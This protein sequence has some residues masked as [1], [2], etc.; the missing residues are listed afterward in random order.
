MRTVAALSLAVLILVAALVRKVGYSVLVR[1]RYAL[2][3]V[4]ATLACAAADLVST[5]YAQSIE[6]CV[7]APSSRF[8]S[9]NAQDAPVIVAQDMT[10]S[11]QRRL[12]R[13]G[14]ALPLPPRHLAPIV[15]DAGA[16]GGVFLLRDGSGDE[17]YR[18]FHQPLMPGSAPAQIS[19][20]GARVA[21]PLVLKQSGIAVFSSTPSEDARWG[22]LQH[23]PDGAMR[24]IMQQPGAWQ[25]V[26]ASADGATLLVQEVFGLYDRV[27]YRL[28]R[29]S[30]LKTP[31]FL[32]KRPLAIRGAQ[33]SPNGKL[34]Y[35]ILATAQRSSAIVIAD[36]EAGK[37]SSFKVAQ[38]P[39][40]ALQLSADGSTLTALENRGG[41]SV[42]HIL[43]TTAQNLATTVELEGWAYDLVVDNAGKQ[44]GLT[45]ER[46]GYAA[47]ALTLA[48]ATGYAV[49]PSVKPACADIEVSAVE[50]RRPKSVGGMDVLPAILIEAKA[51]AAALR[52]LIIAF[53]GG[54]EG[55]WRRTSHAELAA[56]ADQL[57]AAIMLPNVAGST[58]YGLRY[59]ATDDGVKRGVVLAEIQLLLDWARAQ[60]RIDAARIAVMGAS[61]GGYLALLAQ[62]Q[63]DQELRGALSHVGISDLGMFL[64]ETPLTRR[65]L[66]R[67][68]YGDERDK[69]LAGQLK[70]YSP[71]THFDAIS[72]PVFLSHGV[73]DARVPLAQSIRLADALRQRGKPVELFTLE[74]EGHVT[75][76]PEARIELTQRQAAFLRQILTN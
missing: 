3:P 33:L 41:T 76:R 34:A 30:G 37:V 23:E 74:N 45:L 25:P 49:P 57:D 36:V 70:T 8:L 7:R 69:S 53:H 15:R 65:A 9:F 40:Y 22:L 39:L 16:R 6:R 50:I 20:A 72:R 68:E 5:G 61:Y 24:I 42:L 51:T 2:A 56:L 19:L 28:D 43:P 14:N 47:Q 66:R 44:V 64:S 48:S 52:P 75:R 27:L 13:A 35:V 55:Q 11:P 26:A 54:P 10:A 1:M 32:G 29:A 18:L 71:I 21:T 60:P 4:L 59:S 58:G 17:Q 46:P 62:T 31:L 63:F 38:W 12:E 67:A 73:N